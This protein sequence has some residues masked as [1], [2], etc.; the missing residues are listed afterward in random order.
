MWTD[1]QTNIQRQKHNILG[2]YND[3][4]KKVM[5]VNFDERLCQTTDLRVG[6]VGSRSPSLMRAR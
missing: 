2:G 5:R 3:V 1:R 6:L 4:C